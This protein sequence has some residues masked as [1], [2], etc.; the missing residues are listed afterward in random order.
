M[1]YVEDYNCLFDWLNLVR[2]A[3][4]LFLYIEK[5]GRSEEVI[6]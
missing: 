5:C 3:S 1:H 4:S 6:I 2:G